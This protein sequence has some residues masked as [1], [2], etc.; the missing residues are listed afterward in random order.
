MISY[1]LNNPCDLEKVDISIP[2][3]SDYEV[4][5]RVAYTGVCASDISIYKGERTPEVNT[6]DKIL[7]GHEPSGVIDKVG[8]KVIG[9]KVGDFVTAIGVWGCFTEYVVTEPINILRLSP[10][11]S[12]IEGSIVEVLPSL[13]MTALKTDI[14][15]S[16]DVLI[17]GQGLTGLLL[18][19]LVFYKGCKNLIVAD[20]YE[21]KLTIS[22]EFGATHTINVSEKDLEEEVKKIVPAG[23]D[24]CIVA[25]RDGNDIAK[26][27]DLVRVRG[28]IVNFGAIGPC[29]GF[30]YFKFH[31]K[32]VSVVK[33][34]MN[35]SGIWEHRKIWKE[36]MELLADGILPSARLLTHIFPMTDLQKAIDLRLNY[37]S[38]AIHVLVENDWAKELRLDK[39]NKQIEEE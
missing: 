35:L 10:S 4:R 32:G 29:D 25:T 15:E 31:C 12:L 16:T 11:I 19:R 20:L 38:D 3:P 9:L 24:V 36:V 34:S 6:G 17:I 1:V 8:S 14:N 18:T 13:A 28:R 23:V 26:A 5:V 33:E 37:S 2:E 21:N 27:L 30:D 22:K 39:H 7:I